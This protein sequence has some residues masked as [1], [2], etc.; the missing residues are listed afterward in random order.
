MDISAAD[1][2]RHLHDI[3]QERGLDLRVARAS[4]LMAE[5]LEKT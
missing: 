3:L 1:M 4:A 2:I 5:T